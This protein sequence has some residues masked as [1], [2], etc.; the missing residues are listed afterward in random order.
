MAAL[1][2]AAAN[3]EF[4]YLN[5]VVLD[6]SEAVEQKV[7]E[8][9]GRGVFGMGLASRA[10]TAAAKQVVTSSKI[11]TKL[12]SELATQ[13][14][15]KVA[16]MGITLEVESKFQQGAYV[17][18]RARIT[19]VEP[20]QLVTFAKGEEF[21]AKFAQMLECFEALE[22]SQALDTVRQKIDGKVT[23]SMMVKLEEILPAKLAENH[24]Q[25][26]C[27]CKSSAQQAVRS[28]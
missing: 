26:E 23:E 6:V 19:G 15:A 2:P 4:F 24:V 12:A 9:L 10:A 7:G 18:L 17:V 25:M 27:T 1:S 22:L 14:P 16:E 8:K 11:A 3:T 13:I 5:C 28:T 20:T 21:G